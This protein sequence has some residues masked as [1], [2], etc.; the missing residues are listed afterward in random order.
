ME[1]LSEKTDVD[2]QERRR[3]FCATVMNQGGMLKEEDVREMPDSR[4]NEVGFATMAEVVGQFRMAIG[5]RAI[6][7]GN[8]T[9]ELPDGVYLFSQNGKPELTV[10]GGDDAEK[11]DPKYIE[12]Q[13]GTAQTLEE[14]E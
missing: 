10:H 12:H 3:K 13:F 2:T 4:S 11:L 6:K 1:H 8:R 5:E 7:I 14:V 9:K